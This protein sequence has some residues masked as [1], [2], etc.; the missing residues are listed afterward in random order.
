MPCKLPK[1]SS[2]PPPMLP[3][4]VWEE[5]ASE[6][7][8]DDGDKAA[9]SNEVEEARE[10]AGNQSFHELSEQII[11]RIGESRLSSDL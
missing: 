1:I 9:K 11:D 7:Q 4:Q 2:R 8:A 10:E 6:V 3:D 5:I